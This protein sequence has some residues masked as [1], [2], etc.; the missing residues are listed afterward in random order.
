MTPEPDRSA[1]VAHVLHGIR[2]AGEGESACEDCNN[3]V[4]EVCR[5]QHTF[6]YVCQRCFDYRNERYDTRDEDDIQD[7]RDR[8]NDAYNQPS[9]LWKYWKRS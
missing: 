1:Q 3:V 5:V 9:I 2:Q 8:V 6:E 7:Y 4:C